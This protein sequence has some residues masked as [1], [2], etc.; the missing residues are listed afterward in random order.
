[1]KKLVLLVSLSAMLAGADFRAGVARV[2]ITPEAPIWMAG[3]AARTHTS[4][5]VMHELWAKALALE[6][7]RGNR[8]VIVT[9]D[10]IGLPRA[11]ADPVAARLAKEY[12]LNRAALLLNSS[13]THSGP[14]LRANLEL[15]FD[16]VPDERHIV[17]DYSQK[18]PGDLVSVV[19]AALGKLEPAELYYG[20]GEVGFAVN[21][22]ERTAQGFRIG[23]NPQGP[24]DHS[25]PVLKVATSEGKLLAVVF[26]YACHNTTLTADSYLISGDYAGFAQLRLEKIYPEATAMF[27]MLC[28]ADQ[29]PHPRGKPELAEQYGNELASEVDRVLKRKLQ[30]VRAPLRSAF[31]IVEPAFAMHTR[32][33][34]EQRLNDP[35]PVYRRH[36]KYMLTTY[37]Q[38]QP[39]RKVLYPVQALRFGKNLTIIALGGEVV[40]DYTLRLYREYPKENLIVAGYSNDVMCYIP[41][42]RVLQ[43]GGYEAEESMIY[44]GQPGPFRDDVEDV[45]FHA[46]HRTLENVGVRGKQ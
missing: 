17:E 3:F 42:S 39:I 38:K 34:F 29:N 15:M 20:R 2:R 36:A 5:G 21:R 31:Q 6:D 23:V 11:I 7:S 33:I 1:M 22:R 40:V 27:L 26:G 24:V 28:G 25:V 32:T 41:S 46:I 30:R 19:A 13:H 35:R 10:L 9:T 12:G 14:L 18:L 45:I 4:I 16:L 43:E 37:D 44:Y 8:A